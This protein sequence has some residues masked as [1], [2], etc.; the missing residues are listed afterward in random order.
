M[1]E[2]ETP[3]GAPGAE[4]SLTEELTAYLDGELEPG[5]RRRVESRLATDGA[6]REELHRLERTWR[7]LDSLPAARVDESFTR[8]TMAMVATAASADVERAKVVA[9]K[10]RF[11]RRVAGTLLVAAAFLF[12]VGLGRRLWPDPNQELLR[13]LPLLEHFDAYRHGDSIEF[14]RSLDHD[15]VFAEEN[16]HAN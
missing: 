3:D 15:G 2:N 5:A 7:L 6:Y 1:P 8:S 9:P 10:K 4:A 12:G 11:R 14:L 16:D 13:E